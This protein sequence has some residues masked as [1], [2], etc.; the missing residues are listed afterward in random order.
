MTQPTVGTNPAGA[1]AL[2]SNTAKVVLLA[3]VSIH[4][5]PWND[6]QVATVVLALSGVIDVAVY[7]GWVRPRISAATEGRAIQ[8]ASTMS[9]VR[10]AGPHADGIRP[11]DVDTSWVTMGDQPGPAPERALL[12]PPPRPRPH[13]AWD[14]ETP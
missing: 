9:T 7:F 3:L 1:A 14:D 5:L 4:V 6:G 2:I 11:P 12:D 8:L 13:P 10:D